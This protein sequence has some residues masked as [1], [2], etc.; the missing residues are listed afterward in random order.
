[1]K[2]SA[3][4][5]LQLASTAP[6]NLS[7]GDTMQVKYFGRDPQTGAVR[8]SRKVLEVANLQAVRMLSKNAR[9]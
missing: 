8:L 4:T 2:I 3:R 5:L 9:R 1:L 6:L 7:V